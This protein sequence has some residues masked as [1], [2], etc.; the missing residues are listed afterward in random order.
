MIERSREA[1]KHSP[2]KRNSSNQLF[3]L[4]VGTG[5]LKTNTRRLFNTKNVH[6]LLSLPLL[7]ILMNRHVANDYLSH[8]LF[9]LKY[10]NN[11]NR[12]L[13][14]FRVSWRKYQYLNSEPLKMCACGRT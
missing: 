8:R 7:L 9:T 6:F 5:L 3:Q 4:T 10:T 14:T 1:R 2:S 12:L 11:Y 13:V